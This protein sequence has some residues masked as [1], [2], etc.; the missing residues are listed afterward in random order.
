MKNCKKNNRNIILEKENLEKQ[1]EEFKNLMENITLKENE[2][3]KY[4][5][6]NEELKNIIEENDIIIHLKED[7]IKSIF[8][9]NFDE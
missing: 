7:E 3:K 4:K 2:L 6:E 8:L 1:N 5:E 9:D